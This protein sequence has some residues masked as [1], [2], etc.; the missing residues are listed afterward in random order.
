MS[1]AVFAVSTDTGP[2]LRE[3]RRTGAA[4]ALPDRASFTSATAAPWTETRQ[5]VAL[6]AGAA[7]EAL[8]AVAGPDEA[9]ADRM[10]ARPFLSTPELISALL[11]SSIPVR[12]SRPAMSTEMPPRATLPTLTPPESRG[13][14]R[15]RP[16]TSMRESCRR[17][18]A[19]WDSMTRLRRASAL[20]EARVMG[21]ASAK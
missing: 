16:R 3:P 21:R 6:P 20:A 18:A 15:T 1:T 10:V 5:A 17:G 9:R 8:G 14:L 4:G 12:T 7:S 13:A 19:S 11:I 2:I